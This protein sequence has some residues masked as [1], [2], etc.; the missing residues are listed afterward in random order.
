MIPLIFLFVILVIPIIVCLLKWMTIWSVKKKILVFF[1][2][3]KLVKI[4]STGMREALVHAL[5]V[6]LGF[7]MFWIAV[8]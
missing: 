1:I 6:D 4:L 7:L 5:H 8:L 3:L 2:H